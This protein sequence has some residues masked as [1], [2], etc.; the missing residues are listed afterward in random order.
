MKKSSFNYNKETN[1]PGISR[2]NYEMMVKNLKNQNKVVKLFT[3]LKS[4]SKKKAPNATTPNIKKA[5]LSMRPSNFKHLQISN[6][7]YDE[8][9]KRFT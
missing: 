9:L 2:K 6:A 4:I 7:N 5:L 8:M 1:F 3:T